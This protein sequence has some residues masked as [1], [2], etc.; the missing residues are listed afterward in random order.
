MTLTRVELLLLPTASYALACRLHEPFGQ[1]VV[2]HENAPVALV[3]AKAPFTYNSTLLTPTLSDE[4]TVTE[5]VP[6]TVLPPVGE[7]I[8]VVGGDV[9]L[10]DGVPPLAASTAL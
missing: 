10:D 7:V 8:V 2:F 9:S 6:D 4:A 5:T 1:V 3:P